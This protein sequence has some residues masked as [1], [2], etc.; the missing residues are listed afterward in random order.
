[1]SFYEFPPIPPIFFFALDLHHLKP[2][3]H[4]ARGHQDYGGKG[5]RD[6]REELQTEILAVLGGDDGAADGRAGEG[7]QGADEQQDAAPRAD[8]AQV[9]Y[10]RDDGR[11][12]RD[13]GAGSEPVDGAEG[14]CRARGIARNPERERDDARERGNGD[15]RVEAAH[16][17]GGDAGDDTAGDTGASHVSLDKNGDA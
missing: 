12:Q 16:A 13:E 2:D 4:P 10:L 15:H 1:M 8:L 7:A 14:E 9:A 5:Y 17:I 6:A 3:L 11:G